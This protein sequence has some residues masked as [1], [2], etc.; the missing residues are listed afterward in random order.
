MP[1]PK[2]YCVQLV[3]KFLGI[4]GNLNE[5]QIRSML[6]NLAGLP[7]RWASK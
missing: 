6:L 1:W 7:D 3:I 5:H 2:D 4:A